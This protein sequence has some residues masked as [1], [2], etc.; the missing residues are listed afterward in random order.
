VDFGTEYKRFISVKSISLL[1]LKVYHIIQRSMN[2]TQ[3]PGLGTWLRGTALVQHVKGP[4]FDSQ[5]C[6]QQKSAHI[7]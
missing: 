2:K 6:K 1:F 4:D 3:I 5:H 7:P